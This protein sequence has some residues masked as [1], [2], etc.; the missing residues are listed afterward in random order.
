MYLIEFSLLLAYTKLR[1][2]VL[3]QVRFVFVVYQ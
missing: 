1:N 2:L 3:D